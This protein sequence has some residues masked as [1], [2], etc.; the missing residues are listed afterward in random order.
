MAHLE[1]PWLEIQ[2]KYLFGYMK[3][4][5]STKGVQKNTLHL[6]GTGEAIFRLADSTKLLR[7]FCINRQK[8]LFCWGS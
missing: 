4:S 2:V 6:I 5:K 7:L 8:P 1:I 3:L